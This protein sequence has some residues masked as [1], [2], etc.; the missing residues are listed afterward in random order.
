MRVGLVNCGLPL[1]RNTWT[2]AQFSWEIDPRVTSRANAL[3]TCPCP[4]VI[5][6]SVAKS[7]AQLLKS[8]PVDLLVIDHSCHSRA[9][10]FFNRELRNE[11]VWTQWLAHSTPARVV[12]IW[13]EADVP[14]VVGPAG[15][16]HR[17]KLASHGYQSQ[18]PDCPSHGSRR[19]S[20]ALS[21]DR[22]PHQDEHGSTLQG[23]ERR[24]GTP[25]CLTPTE[26]HV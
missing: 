24:V 14:I 19:I 9:K 23:Y 10:D 25:P 8:N 4:E 16:T 21:D 26:A 1:C 6:E 5:Y 2:H 11:R 13:R 3:P 20:S 17:K 12:E 7:P 22:H 18:P 15:K